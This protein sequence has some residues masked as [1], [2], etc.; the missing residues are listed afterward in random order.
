M[1]SPL[2]GQHS[3]SVFSFGPWTL[4]RSIQRWSVRFVKGLENMLHEEDLRELGLFSLK[5][6]RLRGALTALSHL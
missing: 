2:D 5:K 3:R 4:K 6:R 1:C